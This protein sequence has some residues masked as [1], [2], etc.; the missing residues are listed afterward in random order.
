MGFQTQVNLQQA[1]A[2][3]GDFASSNPF[4]STPSPEGG[5]VAGAAG[6][7]VGQFGWVQS[8]GVTVLNTGAGKP[9]GFVHRS[10]NALISNYLA[11]SGMTIPAGFPVVLL[12]GGDFWDKVT[13]S[14]AT[15]LQKAFAKFQDGTMQPAA[16]GSTIAGASVTGSIATTTLT[17]TAVASG[18]LL[19]GDLIAGANVTAGTYITAQLTGTPG[20]IGTYTVSI[21]QT[22]ASAT[23]TSTSYIETNGV[24]Q[25]AAS[26][27]ELAVVSLV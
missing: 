23:V 9:D 18:T 27:G 8:D 19:V 6:V 5:F 11:E 15:R 4:R 14:A 10:E 13:V 1:P 22:A 16:A 21:S 12:N 26:V 17:V 7:V 20:G 24:I 2:V 25:R 3:E